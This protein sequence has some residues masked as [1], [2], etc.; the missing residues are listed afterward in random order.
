M[1]DNQ[2]DDRWLS[3]VRVRAYLGT[4]QTSFVRLRQSGFPPP[5]DVRANRPWWKL[6]TIRRWEAER[7]AKLAAARA[8]Q[9]DEHGLQ[10]VGA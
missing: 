2:L 3:Q 9:A 4:P 7:A 1:T 5:D 8:A 10:T 6:S